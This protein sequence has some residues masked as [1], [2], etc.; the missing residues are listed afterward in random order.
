[1]VRGREY[2]DGVV[3]A[4]PHK[5]SRALCVTTFAY[6][7]DRDESGNW[8]GRLRPRLVVGMVVWHRSGTPAITNFDDTNTVIQKG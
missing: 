5:P 6:D 7:L 3:L 8:V 2:T 1:V 4:D